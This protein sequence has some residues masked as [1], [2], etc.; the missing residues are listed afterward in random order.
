MARNTELSKQ[1]ST[2]N[3][4][5]DSKANLTIESTRPNYYKGVAEPV[6][7]IASSSIVGMGELD[8]IREWAARGP[9]DTDDE[10]ARE[11][12]ELHAKS[13]KMVGKWANTV[14]GKRMKRLA[15]RED[16]MRLIEEEKL[17]QD[18]EWA[19]ILK[20][21]RKARIEKSQKQQFYESDR[22]R[23]LNSKL[24]LAAV[25]QERELQ[26]SL[27]KE[28]EALLQTVDDARIAQGIEKS[29][30]EQ[31]AEDAKRDARKAS[32][33]DTALHQVSQAQRKHSQ[34]DAERKA[35]KS[36]YAGQDKLHAEE[37]KTLNATKKVKHVEDAHVFSEELQEC[38]RQKQNVKDHDRELD[39]AASVRNDV[40]NHRKS[41]IARRR[42]EVDKERMKQRQEAI[43]ATAELVA[44]YE[45][46][47]FAQLDCFLSKMSAPRRGR[48]AKEEVN[49]KTRARQLEAIEEFRQQQITRRH[50]R[51][52]QAHEES[53]RARLE[54]DTRFAQFRHEIQ[55]K[56]KT[57]FEKANEIKQ[58]NMHLALETRKS[59]SNEVDSKLMYQAKL[60]EIRDH[61]EEEFEE[62]AASLL[63]EWV[64]AGRDVAPVLR[65]IQQSNGL[66]IRIPVGMPKPLNTSA[67]LGFTP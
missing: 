9:N 41:A 26:I 50:E 66:K 6:N 35:L 31:E 34:E 51:E 30:R 1:G 52:Q 56:S 3:A 32:I 28:R 27:R 2:P 49:Q 5:K 14:M 15:Q 61:E 62:Y 44:S 60:L 33:R 45:Q 8:R 17:R 47:R 57:T 23:E 40:F 65:A 36:F 59:Q 19:G 16:R 46:K 20:E 13:M 22:V 43:D 4:S 64:E 21:E 11:K 54:L 37:M 58:F 39:A 25:M 12:L 67:R 38:I 53:R 29:K 18:Q 63:R 7:A 10:V 48:S 42:G 24:L 55:D